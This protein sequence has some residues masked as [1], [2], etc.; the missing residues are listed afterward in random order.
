MKKGF[1]LIETIVVVAVIGLT[2]PILFAILFTLMRQQVKIYQLSQ[3][4]REGDY[5]INIIDNTIRNRAVII[6]KSDTIIDSNIVC[7]D[8]VPAYPPLLSGTTVDKLYFLDKNNVWFGFKQ[9]GTIIYS[10]SVTSDVSLTSSKTGISGFSISCNR[11]TVYSPPSVSISFNI[12]YNTTSGRP[13]ETTS[14]YY[15]TRI[16]LRNY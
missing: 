10:S 13:E 14:M 12:S 3:I 5:I 9:I 1:T 6:Y 2:I 8:L 11:N 7:N 15:Q 4:K 16:K